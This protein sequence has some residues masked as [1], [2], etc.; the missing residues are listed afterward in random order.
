MGCHSVQWFVNGMDPLFDKPG[1]AVRCEPH[2]FNCEKKHNLSDVCS[3]YFYSIFAIKV[4]MQNAKVSNG[5][6][7]C[8]LPVCFCLS[9]H[10]SVHPNGT[11]WLLTKFDM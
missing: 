3:H 9:V 8:V 2:N 6:I 11:S 7:T 10:L 1:N 5:F 4:Q